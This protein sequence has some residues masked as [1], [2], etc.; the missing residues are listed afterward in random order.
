MAILDNASNPLLVPD[1]TGEMLGFTDPP[2]PPEVLPLR[3]YDFLI[4]PIRTADITE[5]KLFVERYLA[6]PQEVWE[7]IQTDTFRL[8]DLWDVNRILDEHLKFQKNIV[9]WTPELERPITDKLD[10]AALRR[11]I[12]LSVPL[13]KIRGTEDAYIRGILALVLTKMRVWNW[14]DLR[15]ILDETEIGQG[16]QGRDP[17]ILSAA[18]EY[19]SDVRIVDG[20]LGLDRTLLLNMLRLFRPSGERLR[21]HWIDFLEQFLVTADDTQWASDQ[22]DPI[23]VAD[24][25]MTLDDDVSIEK[26]NV[27]VA[28]SLD[29]DDYISYWRIRG[30]GDAATERFGALF[31]WQDDDNYYQVLLEP[32]S[33]SLILVER[34][35]T[36]EAPLVTVDLEATAGIKVHESVFYGIRVHVEAVPTGTRIRVYLDGEERIDFTDT[37]APLTRG[38]IGVIHLVGSTLDLSEAELFQLPLASNFIDINEAP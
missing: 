14:F 8:L 2:T 28:D 17:F 30:T 27:I 20:A 31:Y 16:H 11:L 24:R 33:E 9:G 15:F 25:L 3:M 10:F 5:G 13:W 12:S 36:V 19:I 38:S 4:K 1:A 22:V 18:E 21:V 35:A 32:S 7:T 6:G 29:W 23:P 34:K 26:A 37:T